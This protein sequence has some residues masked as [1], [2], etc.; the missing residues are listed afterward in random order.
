MLQFSQISAEKLGMKDFNKTDRILLLLQRLSHA[1]LKRLTEEE[2]KSIL[3]DLSR[4]SFYRLIAELCEDRG[5][6]KSI[7]TRVKEEDKTYYTLNHKEWQEFSSSEEESHFLLDCLRHIG[8]Y[9]STLADAL[10]VFEGIKSKESKLNQKFIYL[11]KIQGTPLNSEHQKFLQNIIK[12]ILSS[13]KVLMKYNDK[14]FEFLPLSLCQ[15]RDEIYVIGAKDKFSSENMR[16]LKIVRIQELHETRN[17]F[18]YPSLSQYNPHQLFAHT[19]GLIQ[20]D[21]KVAKLKIHGH[22]RKIIS[23]KSFFNSKLIESNAD[24]DLI[25]CKYTNV[26]EFLGQVFIYA[27]DV[28]VEYPLEVKDAFIEKAIKAITRNKENKIKEAA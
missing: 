24:Y 2:I 6:L 16:S 27:Q 15:Y 20:G 28:E 26:D 21:V 1:P 25:E 12:A 23:E 5:E 22:S 10:G 3:G 9:F 13:T 18:R 8:P 11:S 17:S 14:N 7:L 4:A 19:S